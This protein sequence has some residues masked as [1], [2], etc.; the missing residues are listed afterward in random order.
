[1]RTCPAPALNRC[2]IGFLIRRAQRGAREFVGLFYFAHSW[3]AF[4]CLLHSFARS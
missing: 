2:L 1:M 4:L 3:S